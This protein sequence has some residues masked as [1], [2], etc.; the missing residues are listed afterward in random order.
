MF[1]PV[2]QHILTNLTGGVS[3]P[4][5]YPVAASQNT[6]SGEQFVVDSIA[7]R[8]RR[9]P[10]QKYALFGYSQGA[11]LILNVLRQLSPP[12][13]ESIKLV[14]LVGNP[15]YMP[16]KSS[17]VNAT[18]Q[19]HEKALLGM[20][21]EKAIASNRTTQLLKEMDQSGNVLDY[22]LAVSISRYPCLFTS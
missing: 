16:G 13:L 12:A 5:E 9:C 17:N 15:F 19:H 7:H 1:Y 20:F 2:I 6:S 18:A 10:H 8:L 3:L 22:C 4:V 21:A 14:I 11:T